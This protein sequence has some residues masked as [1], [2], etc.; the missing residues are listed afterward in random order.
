MLELG[1]A[2]PA[3]HQRVHAASARPAVP[4]HGLNNETLILYP[5]QTS[6]TRCF[7]HFP[8]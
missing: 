1:C 3:Q 8:G 2:T 7:M 5:Y 4:T 6:Y